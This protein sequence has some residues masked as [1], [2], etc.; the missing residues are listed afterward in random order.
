MAVTISDEMS[1]SML[2]SPRKMTVR[3]MRTDEPRRRSAR[4]PFARTLESATWYIDAPRCAR[5]R[6]RRRPS[7]CEPQEEALSQRPA[8]MRG[9]VGRRRP[10]LAAETGP[11]IAEDHREA[12]DHVRR[13]DRAPARAGEHGPQRIAHEVAGSPGP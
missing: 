2:V 13:L 8:E 9:D 4:P 6:R 12:S 11:E 10:R 1:V 3:L 7:P 5:R